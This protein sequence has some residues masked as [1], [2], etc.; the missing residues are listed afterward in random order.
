MT[1]ELSY[2]WY[3]KDWTYSDSTFSLSL[4]ERGAYRELIDLAMMSDNNIKPEWDVWLRKWNTS[5]SEI[6]DIMVKLESKGLIQI[7]DDKV[8][9]PSVE[10]R[11]SSKRN[12]SKGGLKTAQSTANGTANDTPKEKEK[13]K[14]KVNIVPVYDDFFNYALS[15]KG[16]LNFSHDALRLKYDSWVENGWKDGNDKKIKNWK[17]KLLNS[18]PYLKERKQINRI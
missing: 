8:F 13:E 11:I 9:I 3:P 5:E 7:S 14:E 6:V 12:G 10:R 2:T 15:K 18:L 1:R 4:A 17:T 16:N